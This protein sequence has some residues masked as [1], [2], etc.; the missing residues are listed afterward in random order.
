MCSNS[1]QPFA[2][3]PIRE[4][5]SSIRL[6]ESPEPNEICFFAVFP[7]A[8][9]LLAMHLVEHSFHALLERSV[10]RSLVE[11]AHEVPTDL[12]RVVGEVQG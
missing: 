1:V 8:L 4:N 7:R 5:R 11:F 2:S 6:R 12:E 10:L 3:S 9:R